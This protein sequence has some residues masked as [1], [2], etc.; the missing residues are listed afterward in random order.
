M[1]DHAVQY[2][3]GRVHANGVESF[4]S[5][6][7]RRVNGSY[8]SAEPFH[9][10][11]YLDEQSFRYNHRHMTDGERFILAM[12]QLVGR[13]LTFEQLTGKASKEA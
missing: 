7:K 13:R 5:L 1:I 6:F 11:R 8:V 9:S 4:W 12:K 10:F 2:V 3:D